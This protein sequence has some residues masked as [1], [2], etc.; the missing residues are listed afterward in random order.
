M[1]S[2]YFTV[3]IGDGTARKSYQ[4]VITSGSFLL[5]HHGH[6]RHDPRRQ[7]HRRGDPP[8]HHQNA[9]EEPQ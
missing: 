8:H 1:D 4:Q 9:E 3:T 6:P 7:P 5:R 2:V